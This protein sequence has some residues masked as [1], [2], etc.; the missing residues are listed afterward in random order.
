MAPAHFA[1]LG[2][3]VAALDLVGGAA[4]LDGRGRSAVHYA[5]E[6]G[7]VALLAHL[8]AAGARAPR[9]NEGEEGQTKLEA[10]PRNGRKNKKRQ[11]QTSPRQTWSAA[12][13]R[14]T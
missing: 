2:G 14:R 11:A 5:A 9:R 7:H 10:Q 6:R 3:H 13:R 4:R 1:A 12:R 8:A